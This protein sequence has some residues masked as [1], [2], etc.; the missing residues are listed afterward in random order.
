MTETEI[1]RALEESLLDCLNKEPANR[2][3]DAFEFWRR[4][5][6]IELPEPWTHADAEDWWR[7]QMPD[8]VAS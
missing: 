1:P 3:A 2:P 5:D 7:L 8:V 4:L 6:A